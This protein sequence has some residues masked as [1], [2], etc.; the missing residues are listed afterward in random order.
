[1]RVIRFSTLAEAGRVNRTAERMASS[2]RLLW[3]VLSPHKF[4]SCFLI[5]LMTYGRREP[6]RQVETMFSYAFPNQVT[7]SADSPVAPAPTRPRALLQAERNERYKAELIC[8]LDP[9]SSKEQ[10]WNEREMGQEWKKGNFS[11]AWKIERAATQ[12]EQ[13][14]QRD[15]GPD[16]DYGPFCRI[17]RIRFPGL[18]RGRLHNAIIRAMNPR[19]ASASRALTSWST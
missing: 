2:N 10:T 12:A 18:V 3:P 16:R 5:S 1:M 9:S 7:T 15:R 4:K 6:D 13:Q 19:S 14:R 11:E 17:Y 8:S